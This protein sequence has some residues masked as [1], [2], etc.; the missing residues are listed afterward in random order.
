MYIILQ[1]SWFYVEDVNQNFHISK[2]VV[3]LRRK[4]ILHEVI[5]PTTIPQVQSQVTEQLYMGMLNI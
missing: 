2:Y 5:L 3:P 1:L 4:V